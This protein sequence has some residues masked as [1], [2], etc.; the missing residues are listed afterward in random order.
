MIRSSK[1]TLKFANTGKRDKIREFLDEYRRVMLQFVDLLWEQEHV[2]CL[3]P[4]D[5]TDKIKTWLSARAVQAAGKQA[6]GIV[7][8]TRTKQ[9]KRL[10]M[11][12]KLNKEGKFKQARKLLAICKK[13]AAGKPEIELIEAELDSR[14]VSIELTSRNSFDGWIAIA[15]GGGIRTR[16]PVRSHKHLNNLLS[17]G[18]V[19]PGIRLASDRITLMFELPEPSLVEDGRTI[20]IDIGQ[21][22]TISCSDGQTVDKDVHG[23]TYQSI[24]AKLAR[25][26]R[27]SSGFRK[28]DT[29]RGNYLRWC[30]NMLN[31]DG[32]KTVKM[33]KIR[34]L[35]KG[36]RNTR[37][38]QHWNYAELFDV[39]Q[40][41]LD[42]S[43]V[44][45]VEVSPTYTSQRC[46]ACGWVRRRNRKEKQFK[47][48]KC[49]HTQDADLNASRNISLNLLPI[50]EK[51][52]LSKVSRTGFYWLET[53]KEP[54]VPCARE[55]QRGNKT[56]C[57]V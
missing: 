8:G 14:F 40:G 29:H 19:K 57:F 11:V 39:L 55:I 13:K 56:P 7:R 24:C 54:I 38:M 20:G 12:K 41:K 47:C 30:V 5:T 42:E 35:R 15:L 22:T 31:L 51:E 36:R 16:I 25:K 34:H 37:T 3:I 21:K 4:K 52:R 50:G 10:H 48:D 9:A 18:T 43:G 17:Q 46:S 49:G 6:S 26:K 2:P 28:A 44:Q 45:T 27:G 1:V 53:G 33:E 32:V 23:H